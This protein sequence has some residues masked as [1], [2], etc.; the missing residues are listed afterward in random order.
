M[1][2]TG[3]S[4]GAGPVVGVVGADPE[5]VDGLAAAVGDVDG[6]LVTGAVD[7]VLCQEPTIVLTVGDDALAA[8]VS[9]DHEGPVLPADCGRGVRSVAS[10]RVGVALRRVLRDGDVERRYP[11]LSVAVDGTDVARCFFDV[12]LV[13]DRPARISE[14]T[15]GSGGEPVARFRADGVVVATPA[16]SHGY[17]RAAGGPLLGDGVEAVS[18]VPI[19]PFVTGP[20]RWVLPIDDLSLSNEREE[21]V[22]LQADD[23]VVETVDTGVAVSISA[24]PPLS[25]FTVDESE[26][27]FDG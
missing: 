10:D 14:Y 4:E 2:R 25:V 3:A 8:V 26:G 17:A 6:H 21:R 7:E 23:R 9:R 22:V 27:P 5:A 24:G 20:E 1:E 16:G 15:V 12:A 13:T 11:T 19:A 18:V